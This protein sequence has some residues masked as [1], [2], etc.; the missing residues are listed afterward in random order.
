MI[1]I[2]H[3]NLRNHNA[4]TTTDIC[5]RRTLGTGKTRELR[6][7]KVPARLHTEGD[8]RTPTNGAPL[9]KVDEHPNACIIKAMNTLKQQTFPIAFQNSLDLKPRREPLALQICNEYP[10]IDLPKQTTGYSNR[11]AILDEAVS[12]RTLISQHVHFPY[13]ETVGE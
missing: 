10:R 7:D 11:D 9:V 1:F 4:C 12:E 8:L 3:I 5:S 13:V 6:G 2:A